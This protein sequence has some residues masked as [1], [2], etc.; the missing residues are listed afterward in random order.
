MKIIGKILF[1]NADTGQGMIMT[2]DKSKVN[3]SVA[4]WDDFD[5]MPSLGLEI[6]FLLNDKQASSIVSLNYVEE[7]GEDE[8]EQIEEPQDDNPQTEPYEN[9]KTSQEDTTEN[10]VNSTEEQSL[11]DESTG[12]KEDDSNQ[13]EPNVAEIKEEAL[14]HFEEDPEIMQIGSIE[15]VEQELGPREESVTVSMNLPKAVSNYFDIINNNVE[16][17]AAYKKIEGRLDYLIIRR[18]LWTT[19]N[20]LSE[21]DLH[22]I[23]PKI[24]SLSDDLR[25]MATVYNDF[26]RKTKYPPLAYEEVFLACQAEYRKIREGAEKT[27]QRLNQLKTSEKYLGSELKV[28]KEELSK[29]IDTEEFDVLQGELKS[30]NG[31]YVDIVHMMAELDERYKHDMKLL[32]EFEQEY[33]E[34]FYVLFNESAKKYK[35]NIVDIL[36]AQAFT[37]DTQLWTK[38]K[39]SKAVKAHFHRSDIKG[40]FNTRTYLKYYLDTQDSSKVTE[41]N[42]KLFELYDYLTSLQKENVMV[43]LSDAGD[44]IE[45]ESAINKIDKTFFAKS[46]ID[47]K[48]SL[49]WAIKNSIQVL[50]LETNLARIQVEAYLNYYQKYVLVI[51][52]IILLGDLKKSEA[53][54]I[55]KL[56]PRGVSSQMLAKKCKRNFKLFFQKK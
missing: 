51:P 49:K 43:V 20:N 7:E 6:R 52:K 34:D 29:E 15:D 36:S 39:S 41:D 3:F 17:R 23:T 40:E 44:A 35:K 22:I 46:F 2:A 18:F 26:M 12:K 13:Q 27:I 55:H 54:A 19:F 38:A 30:L 48:S 1:F 10:V 45:F 21:I 5:T 42:Q 33:R 11:P 47:E 37:L 25:A 50:V 4:E 24:K 32:H 8:S 31:T 16:K 56:L 9:E 53:Y 14:E 28:K